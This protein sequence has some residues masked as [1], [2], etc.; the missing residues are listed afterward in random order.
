M[1]KRD[2]FLKKKLKIK[3]LNQKLSIFTI[4]LMLLDTFRMNGGT[5]KGFVLNFGTL[6]EFKS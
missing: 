6:L 3:R 4:K 5:E 2:R 1:P